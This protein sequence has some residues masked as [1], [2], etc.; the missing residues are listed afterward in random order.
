MGTL[1]RAHAAFLVGSMRTGAPMQKN[2]VKVL[3]YGEVKMFAWIRQCEIPD[4]PQMVS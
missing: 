2:G 4:R 1:E 3:S